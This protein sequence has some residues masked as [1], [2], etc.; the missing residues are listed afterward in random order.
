MEAWPPSGFFLVNILHICPLSRP[1]GF[2]PRCPTWHQMCRR[3]YFVWVPVWTP[4]KPALLS[5]LH[6][7]TP[8]PLFHAAGE[9]VLH[10]PGQ[11]C[12]TT[13]TRL[14]AL[15]GRR[16]CTDRLQVSASVSWSESFIW[17]NPASW[18]HQL[19]MRPR[20]PGAVSCLPETTRTLFTL[21]R[22]FLVACPGT[23]QKVWGVRLQLLFGRNATPPHHY[24]PFFFFFKLVWSTLSV[25]M[26][27]WQ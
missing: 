1:W 9:L 21:A 26:V 15:R 23:S 18:P 25:D 4:R 7:A 19:W 27:L 13:R 20:S 6:P 14:S 2:H 12:S 8:P 22:C 16:A 5:L 11:T 24:A 3:I 17:C 10:G